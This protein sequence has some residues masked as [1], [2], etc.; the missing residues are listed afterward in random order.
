MTGMVCGYPHGLGNL[1]QCDI[2]EVDAAYLCYMIHDYL[3]LGIY[4]IDID[5]EIYI[6]IYIIYILYIYMARTPIQMGL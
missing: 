4:K 2:Y 5:I 3:A 1:R 6:Y